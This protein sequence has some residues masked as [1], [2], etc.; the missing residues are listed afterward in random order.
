MLGLK[1]GVL[2]WFNVQIYL[3]LC[4]HYICIRGYF[5]AVQ[6]HVI[7]P[8]VLMARLLLT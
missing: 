1:K 8:T 2:R 7:V 4:T 6:F 5:S 3:C